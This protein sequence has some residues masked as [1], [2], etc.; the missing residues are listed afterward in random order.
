[1]L[2]LGEFTTELEEIHYS[3]GYITE[4]EQKIQSLERQNQGLK[5]FKL[6]TE[7]LQMELAHVTTLKDTY[8]EKY[9]EVSMKLLYIDDDDSGIFSESEQVKTLNQKVAILLHANQDL[10]KE[11]KESKEAN[12][13]IAKEKQELQ[14]KIQ[15]LLEIPNQKPGKIL[16]FEAFTQ[17]S[18]ET[19][20]D[21]SQ[22]FNKS[23]M[24][25]KNTSISPLP[26]RPSMGNKGKPFIICPS[27]SAF[28]ANSPKSTIERPSPSMP[29]PKL[30]HLKKKS[31]YFPS[32]LR[33]PVKKSI[34]T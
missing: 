6:E 31:H 17:Y 1:M 25:E 24:C 20:G 18:E 3:P 27:P 26:Q 11:V 21:S 33:K 34:V 14:S 30:K 16:T 13:L 28:I 29:S 5:E 15:K 9:N 12:L 7:R 22:N 32:F 10:L 23:S 8:E 19:F 4:L 2:G